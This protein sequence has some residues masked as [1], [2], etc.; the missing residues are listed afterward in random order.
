VSVTRG[1]LIKGGSDE[2]GSILVLFTLWLPVLILFI[3]FVVDVGNWFVHKRH[4]QLQADAGALAGGGLFEECLGDPVTGNA[5]IAAEARRY[6]GDPTANPRFNGQ[7]PPQAANVFVRINSLG[8]YPNPDFAGGQPCDFVTNPANPDAGAVHVWM[9]EDDLPLFFGVAGLFNVVDVSADARVEVREANVLN[10]LRPFGVR[11]VNPRS[12]GVLFVNDD[13]PNSDVSKVLAADYLDPDPTPSPSGFKRWNNGASPVPVPLNSG[14]QIKEH[15]ST[16]YVLSSLSPSGPN[17]L[18]IGPGLSVDQVCAQVRTD[19]YSVISGTST[20]DV[21]LVTMRGYDGSAS[22]GG[23]VGGVLRDATLNTASTGTPC[24]NWMPGGQP[25]SG[26]SPATSYFLYE[27]EDRNLASSEDCTVRIVADA[28]FQGTMTSLTLAAFVNS[29]SCPNNLNGGT[30]LTGSPPEAN[31][32]IQVS[33]NNGNLSGPN[34]IRLCWRA[35]GGFIDP[36][37]DGIEDPGEQN[38]SNGNN[39]P[40]QG[41]F[42]NVH[43]VFVGGDERSGPIRSA[44]VTANSFNVPSNATPS[45]TTEILIGSQLATTWGDPPVTLRVTGRSQNGSVDCDPALQPHLEKQIPTGCGPFYM[46]NPN[47]DAADPC[48]PPYSNVQAMFNSAQP[49]ICLRID[50]GGS[51][52]DFRKGIKKRILDDENASSCTGEPYGPNHWYQNLLANGPNGVVDE[53]A[54]PEGDPRIVNL[55]MV[56]FGA[57]RGSG[58]ESLVPV[59]N[60]GTF[61]ISGFG[62]PGSDDDPCAGADPAPNGYLIGHFIKYTAGSQ[63]TGPSICQPGSATPCVAVLVK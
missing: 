51:I 1:D 27:I 56:P 4:L 52:G 41:D 7:I 40:C 9:H 38:C 16:I 17:A 33:D 43:R 19:C 42:G 18:Q 53:G 35:T 13:L 22:P 37:G 24:E 26:A 50:P 63:G 25:A 12:A 57:F 30:P 46:I 21:G 14:G 55:F 23:S 28:A 11:D 58:A 15:V 29:S 39:N 44:T 2:R 8:Y 54:F 3:L 34:S 32:S 60:F 31:L 6:A 48:D 36:N 45:I 59:T 5:A 47:L 61:Y 10:L 20:T 49:W 62:L